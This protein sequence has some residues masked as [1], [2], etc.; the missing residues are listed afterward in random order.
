[1]GF[2]MEK[3]LIAIATSYDKKTN[4]Y[5]YQKLPE[6][7]I[8]ADTVILTPD[9]V[10]DADSY[11]NGNGYLKRTILPHKRTKYEANTTILTYKDK[12]TFMELLNEGIML[13]DGECDFDER[14]GRLRYYDDW[15]DDYKEGFFYIPTISFPHKMYLDGKPLYQPIRFAFIEY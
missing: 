1:M 7:W 9:Q 4:T 2:E 6:K 3:G 12:C 10:Q 5:V 13:D 14:R 8:Q 11:T 15:I